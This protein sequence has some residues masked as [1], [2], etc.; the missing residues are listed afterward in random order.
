[1]TKA[2]AVTLTIAAALALLLVRDQTFAAE[3]KKPAP[4]SPFAGKVVVIT[5]NVRDNAGAVLKDA[6]VRQLGSK[7]YLVGKAVVIE[8]AGYT[9]DLV[10]WVAVE[11]VISVFEFK[12]V[13]EVRKYFKERGPEKERARS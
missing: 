4:A 10:T 8:E 7:S 3:G 2:I 13:D 1:M 11:N 6:Q 12:S 9:L 5:M